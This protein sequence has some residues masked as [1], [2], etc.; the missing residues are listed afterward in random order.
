MSWRYRSIS[1]G[2]KWASVNHMASMADADMY[3]QTILRKSTV[4]GE[5]YWWG[6]YKRP[7]HDQDAIVNVREGPGAVGRVTWKSLG[8]KENVGVGEAVWRRR[9]SRGECCWFWGLRR[10]RRVWVEGGDDEGESG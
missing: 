5:R 9:E 8:W 6:E 7:R 1:W 10:G 2:R 3:L 4:S